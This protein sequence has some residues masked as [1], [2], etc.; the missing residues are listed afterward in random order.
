VRQFSCT[1]VR[2]ISISDTI[3]ILTLKTY[4]H[5]P[6]FQPGQFVQLQVHKGNDPLLRR[7]FSIHRI[8]REESTFDIL[9]RVVGRGT[10]ILS[11]V[12]TGD[13]LDAIGPLGNGFQINHSFQ[14]ALIVVGGMGCAPV[15]FLIDELIASKKQITLLWGAKDKIEIFNISFFKKMGVDVRTATENGSMGHHGLVTDLLKSYIKENREK[16]FY[17]GFLCGPESMLKCVQSIIST[18]PFNW[19]VSVEKRMACGIGVCL[20]CAVKN[21]TD[22]YK[23]ACSEGPVFNLKEVVFH[24]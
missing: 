22:G 24:E 3:F 18:T 14:N 4:I 17:E 20:G 2:Q 6:I 15:F 5:I 12:A 13:T 9:Y 8:N 10:E 19:Q 23:M 21:K 7:P 16:D 11:M 1:C